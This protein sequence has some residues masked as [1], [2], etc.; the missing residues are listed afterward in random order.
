MS[1]K[2]ISRF[3]LFIENFS[4]I[5]KVHEMPHMPDNVSLDDHHEIVMWMKV[6]SKLHCKT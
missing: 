4:G 2:I 3:C 1:K 5:R 6:V